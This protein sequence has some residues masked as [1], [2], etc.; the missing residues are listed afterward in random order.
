M[1]YMYDMPLLQIKPRPLGITTCS[2]V[3]ILIKQTQLPLLAILLSCFLSHTMEKKL[4]G[5]YSFQHN[6]YPRPATSD[7]QFETPTAVC[8]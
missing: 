2:L 3:T 8:N 6:I 1:S 7:Q 4:Y 5:T